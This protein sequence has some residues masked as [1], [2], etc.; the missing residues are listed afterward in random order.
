MDQVTKTDIL[1]Y[2]KVKRPESALTASWYRN[3]RDLKEAEVN[4]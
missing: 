3:F 2:K 1:R 4:L